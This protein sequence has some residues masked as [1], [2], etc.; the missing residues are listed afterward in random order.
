MTIPLSKCNPSELLEE[1]PDFSFIGRY[2]VLRE[3]TALDLSWH[4]DPLTKDSAGPM[5]S[6]KDAHVSRRAGSRVVDLFLRRDF[7]GHDDQL[8][9]MY[10]LME[11]CMALDSKVCLRI[12]RSQKLATT[13]TLPDSRALRFAARHNGALMS[14]ICFSP[15]SSPM[16]WTILRL[17]KCMMHDQEPEFRI[18]ADEQDFEVLLSKIDMK[19]SNTQTGFQKRGNSVRVIYG[20]GKK[21]GSKSDEDSIDFLDTGEEDFCLL[22]SDDDSAGPMS[23]GID[24]SASL[25]GGVGPSRRNRLNNLFGNS[26]ALSSIQE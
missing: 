19:V 12:H 11:V 8:S 17:M 20:E 18:V 7:E 24:F 10:G 16:E 26:C 15:S 14:D 2:P 25:V 22:Q 23:S 5:F 1:F 13:N 6:L 3:N 21:F 4:V 9:F